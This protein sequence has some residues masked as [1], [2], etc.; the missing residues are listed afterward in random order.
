MSQLKQEMPVYSCHKTVWAL[1]ICQVIVHPDNTCVLVPERS[2][3]SSIVKSPEWFERHQPHDGGYY[4][5]Y[6][7]DY[8]SFS[9]ADQFELG[10]TEVGTYHI[11][12]I[13]RM[14]HEVNRAY[15][16]AIGDQSQKP[17]ADAPQW[18]RD[19]AIKG[20]ELHLSGDYGPEASHES[21]VREK[22]ANGWT[23]GPVKDEVAKTHPCFLP[24]G[25]LSKEQQAKDFIFTAV[26]AGFKP[27]IGRK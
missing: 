24:F 14:A 10:Y 2:D 4:V 22:E 21:W 3:Y 27:D 23:Y 7:D 13:A 18:Q 11:Q 5:V 8:A 20:V 1:K 17:W 6:G 26:V 19:S 16:K 12:M 9:P 15:C 25:V